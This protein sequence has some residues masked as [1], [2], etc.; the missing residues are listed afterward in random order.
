MDGAEHTARFEGLLALS[1]TFAFETDDRG[2]LTFL[3]PGGALGWPGETL[4]G[5][6]GA[7]LLSRSTGLDPFVPGPAYAGRPVVGRRADGG[8]AWLSVSATPLPGPN[9]GMRGVAQAVAAHDETAAAALWRSDVVERIMWQVRQE[10]LAPRMM[11][12]VLDG[13]MGALGGEGAVV[14]DLL[15]AL[16]AQPVRHGCG[17]EPDELLAG[18][19]GAL[20]TDTADPVLFVVDGRPM[21][22][23]PSYTRFG[24]RAGLCIW[25]ARGAAPWSAEDAKLISPVMTLVRM[26]LEHEAIQRE[27]AQQART[28][29][30]TGLHNRRAFLE[31]VGRRIDRLDREGL[32]G[33]LLYVDLD[34]FKQLNDLCGHE[35]GDLALVAAAALLRKTVRPADIVARLGGDEFAIWLDGSDELTGAE[36]AEQLR[37]GATAALAAALPEGAP[38]LTASIGIACRSVH[39]P[40]ALDEVMRRADVALYD[41]K[42]AGRGHWKVARGPSD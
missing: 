3:W 19:V 32:P 38:P 8:L 28:D 34:H 20:Q 16:E 13:L 40:E 35:A 29:P 7:A 2:R 42:R 39:A 21:L 25:R 37:L 4:L 30:L 14:L 15:A 18:M 26:V 41:V 33:T 22:L 36:R 9:A 17:A 1:A 27:L 10:V 5:G 6:P 12:A 24:E 23:C 31:E 11:Q